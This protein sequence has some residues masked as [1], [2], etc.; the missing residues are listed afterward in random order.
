VILSE[1]NELLKDVNVLVIKVGTSSIMRNEFQINRN[2]MDDLA[3][4][5]RGLMD[6]GVQVILVSSGA[7]GLGLGAMG[8]RPKPFE[9]PI[10]QAA[11]SVG[12]GMLMREWRESF[13]R[14]NLRV[15]QILLTYEFYSDRETYLNL[16]NNLSTLMEYGVVPIINENDAVCTKEIEAVF[17]DND[18][19][20]A[21]VAS[22]MESDLLIILSDVDG[23]CDRNPK[24]CDDAHLIPLV[25]DITPDIER[26]AGDP[27][28]TRGVG[29]M[30]TKIQAAKICCLSG[31][32]MIIANHGIED[33]ITKIVD[34]EEIGTLFHRDEKV[35]KTRKRWIILANPSGQIRVD[36]GAMKALVGGKNGLLPSGVIES[37]GEFDRGDIVELVHD[38]K[39][40]A[41]GITDYR[42]EE[43]EKV[44]GAHSND[45]ESI[46]G[47]TN[48]SNV[49]KHEN[50]ALLP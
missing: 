27:T 5:V 49:I 46:L 40:F 7:I 6:R 3:R 11:A 21:M 38:G 33:V 12:Q 22:K 18:T 35:D 50:L 8:A 31:C 16:R 25:E 43:L 23:F 1:R 45:I 28:S 34:G 13:E 17:G 19:L 47:Y 30:R 32:K 15:A 37:I 42:S 2:L 44:K 36:K 9:I 48:Y 24:L 4:Q 39:T 41:K 14:V 20:S 29:G 26:M 10:R